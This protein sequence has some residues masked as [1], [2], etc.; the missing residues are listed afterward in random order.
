MI[1][2]LQGILMVRFLLSSVVPPNRFRTLGIALGVLAVAAMGGDR[3]AKRV[4]APKYIGGQI[5]EMGG[6]TPDRDAALEGRTVAPP[7][8]SNCWDPVICCVEGPRRQ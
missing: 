2:F 7:K 8:S 6:W 1:V 4:M 5:A 3:Y